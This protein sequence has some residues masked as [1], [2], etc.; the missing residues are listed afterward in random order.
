MPSL[1]SPFSFSSSIK[2]V[3]GYV[4]DSQKSLSIRSAENKRVK[5]PKWIHVRIEWN[6]V[7]HCT[8]AM[9]GLLKSLE[10]QVE[11]I[12]HQHILLIEF[13]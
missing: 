6:N 4:P 13:I 1:V 2:I 7:E 5:H 8:A 12:Y 11:T 3:L 9:W 10:L